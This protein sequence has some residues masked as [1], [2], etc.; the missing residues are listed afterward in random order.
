MGRS[1]T[2]LT[3]SLLLIIAMG[4]W[5]LFAADRSPHELLLG[6]GCAVLT[7]LVSVLAWRQ[8]R[9]CFSSTFRQAGVLWRL[10]QFVL[11]DAWKMIVIVIRDLAGKHPGSCYRVVPFHTARGCKGISQIILATVYT[12]VSPNS[13]VI[14][15]SRGRLLFHQAER[16][17][18]PRLI[19][20]L[21]A[22]R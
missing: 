22:H 7:Y 19:S 4:G 1:P 12:T 6:V 9:L 13:I 5:L 3:S 15:V 21:E 10:P 20:D 18:V 8:M 17:G 11:A 2:L 14:G 16:S